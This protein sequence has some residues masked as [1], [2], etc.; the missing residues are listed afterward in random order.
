MLP[1]PSAL[2]PSYYRSDYKEIKILSIDFETMNELMRLYVYFQ[3]ASVTT[4]YF[5]R[6][7]VDP[8]PRGGSADS[9]SSG[10]WLCS[11][12]RGPVLLSLP[13]SAS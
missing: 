12:C 11:L 13:G 10:L 7:V 6:T 5:K 4:D 1:L 8:E 2:H 3:Y 9:Q